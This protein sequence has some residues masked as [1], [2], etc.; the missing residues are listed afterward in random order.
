MKQVNVHEAK[1]HL[2]RLLEEVA[3]GTEVVIAKAGR[4]VAKLVPLRRRK[5]RLGMDR[6]KVWI[7]PGFDEMSDEEIAEFEDAPLIAEPVEK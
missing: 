6:G 5:P 2:S 3:G 4:P 1:T 7:A